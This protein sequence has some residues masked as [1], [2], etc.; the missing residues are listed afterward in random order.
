MTVP[1]LWAS[2][3][4]CIKALYQMPWSLSPALFNIIRL[5]LASFLVMPSLFKFLRQNRSEAKRAILSA[6]VEL[7]FWTVI[8]NIMQMIGLRFTTASRG[9]FL[10]QMC[11]VIVPFAAVASGLEPSLSVPVYVASFVS[12][13]GVALLSLDD[14]T[15]PFTMMGD[16]VLLASA[17]AAALYIL[18]S[19]VHS[20]LP[21]SKA[22][23][24]VKVIAHFF[25]AVLYFIALCV[26][27]ML[28]ASPLAAARSMFVGATPGLLAINAVLILYNAVLVS[29]ASTVLQLRGQKLVSASE[30]VVIFT[31][32]PLWSAAMAIPLGERFG[33]RGMAGALLI[34]IATFLAG[35]R[36]S[37]KPQAALKAQQA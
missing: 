19:K 20:S 27:R 28:K 29:W 12:V 23:T 25:F 18:R 21:D 6:G 4:V 9:A 36:K 32:T 8:V 30:A 22:L 7:G 15:R 1:I 26:P 34:L 3:S 10:H 17:F 5:G 2:Y 11:T 31:S 24:A 33:T 35:Q 14:V 13:L 37:E 16:G